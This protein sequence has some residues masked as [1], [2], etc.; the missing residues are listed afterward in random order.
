M[1][2]ISNTKKIHITPDTTNIDNPD[3]HKISNQSIKERKETME[4]LYSHVVSFQ[5]KTNI[6]VQVTLEFPNS[7]SAKTA[8]K[9]ENDLQNIFRNIQLEKIKNG[10]FQPKNPAL[11]C[12]QSNF[13]EVEKNG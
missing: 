2:E 4:M 3:T 13:T 9:A 5:S 12:S 11:E 8:Q 1:L 7:C 10:A 6:K